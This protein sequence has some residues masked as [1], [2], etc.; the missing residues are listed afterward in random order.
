MGKW[1]VAKRVAELIF[2]DAAKAV[3]DGKAGPPSYMVITG[4]RL[5]PVVYTNPDTGEFHKEAAGA[6]ASAVAREAEADAVLF[7][8]ET[9][10]V[11]RKTSQ[12]ESLDIETLRT[13]EIPSEAPDRREALMMMVVMM[14]DGRSNIFSREIKRDGKER[15]TSVAPGAWVS[16]LPTHRST[17]FHL[18]PWAAPAVH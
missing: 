7:I 2:E 16:S 1:Q 3:A 6:S 15:V 18:T 14:P 5:I 10:F 17:F 4:Q 13:R 8:S 11:T 9:W 12:G